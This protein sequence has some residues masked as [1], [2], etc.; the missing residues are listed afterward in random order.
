MRARTAPS[1]EPEP[2]S[3]SESE[4]AQYIAELVA[5]APPLSADQRDRIVA[6]LRGGT[7]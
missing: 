1:A 2:E 5:A 6:I 4:L 3:E 7:K